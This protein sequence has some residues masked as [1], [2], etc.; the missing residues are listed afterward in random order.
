MGILHFG[1]SGAF[2]GS[3]SFI[4]N[5]HRVQSREADARPYEHPRAFAITGISLIPETITLLKKPLQISMKGQLI[6]KSYN[7]G[8]YD[9]RTSSG[10]HRVHASS[11]RYRRLH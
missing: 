7:K 4:R 8:R 11:L 9:A 5:F 10:L 6:A 1:Q 2:F 3:F